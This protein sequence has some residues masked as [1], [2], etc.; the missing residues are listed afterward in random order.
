VKVQRG[1]SAACL[2]KVLVRGS[3]VDTL[4]AK[5]RLN[6]TMSEIEKQSALRV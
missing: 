5:L 6:R 2:G 1:E 3:G 4:T